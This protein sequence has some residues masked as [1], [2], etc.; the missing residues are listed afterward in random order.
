MSVKITIAETKR[1][2]SEEFD[3]MN[4]DPEEE[5]RMD[6]ME[7]LRRH[8]IRDERITEEIVEILREVRKS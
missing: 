7:V 1:I 4:K 8:N 3:R 2:I 5:F 6:L